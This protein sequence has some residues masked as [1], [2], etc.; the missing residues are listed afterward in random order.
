[1]KISAIK[2]ARIESG[3]RQWQLASKIGI[4]EGTLS[5][6]ETGRI[7]IP[8]AMIE[9]IEA[10]LGCPIPRLSDVSVEAP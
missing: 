5:K 1:M 2:I 7:P 10:V 8:A 6:I 3:L 4:S 9:R